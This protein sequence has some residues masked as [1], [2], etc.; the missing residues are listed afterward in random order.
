MVVCG[1]KGQ[2]SANQELPFIPHLS[3]PCSQF[4]FQVSTLHAALDYSTGATSDMLQI[5]LETQLSI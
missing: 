2:K 3:N 1:G 4:Q 5:I